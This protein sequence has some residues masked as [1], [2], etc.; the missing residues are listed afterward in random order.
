M[1]YA[2]AVGPKTVLTRLQD[3]QTQFG[4]DFRPAALL[5]TVAASG[6]RLGDF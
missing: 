2:D 4:E 5:E 1:F 3:Y 6:G